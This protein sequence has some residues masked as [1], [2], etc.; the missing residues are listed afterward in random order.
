M[1]TPNPSLKE[2]AKNALIWH[3]MK[4]ASTYQ[5]T[6]EQLDEGFEAALTLVLQEVLK[7]L[8]PMKEVDDF[9]VGLGAPSDVH[10]EG[11]N[12]ARTEDI[13]AIKKVLS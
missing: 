3:G 6:P 2:Q 5:F 4:G 7:G 8:P 11:Y 10:N 12:T 1:T 9:G 13:E